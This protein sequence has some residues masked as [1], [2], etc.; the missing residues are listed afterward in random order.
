MSIFT[1]TLTEKPPKY[2]DIR[3]EINENTWITVRYDSV[4]Y[5]DD[6]SIRSINIY[7]SLKKDASVPTAMGSAGPRGLISSQSIQIPFE[8][9][10]YRCSPYIKIGQTAT[11]VVENLRPDSKLENPYAQPDVY[12]RFDKCTLTIEGKKHT[13]V[14]KSFTDN[15][16]TDATCSKSGGNYKEK[17]SNYNLKHDILYNYY[18]KYKL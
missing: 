10:T 8:T 15:R 17:Y 12:L 3:Y 1:F 4:S 2:E 13:L 7:K 11:L 18:L 6:V 16:V 5:S 14:P 9:F